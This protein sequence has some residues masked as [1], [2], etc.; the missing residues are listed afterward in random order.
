MT[1]ETRPTVAWFF[2]C[3]LILT[4]NSVA[5]ANDTQSQS[6][7]PKKAKPA[8]SEPFVTSNYFW[9]WYTNGL[10]EFSFSLKNRSGNDVKKVRFRVIF[11]DRQGNQ[12][13]FQDSET[14]AYSVIP[15]GMTERESVALDIATGSS[16]R[17]LS[18]S[19][20]VEILG[21]EQISPESGSKSP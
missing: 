5:L 8:K 18:A 16:V 11:Y 12:I 3:V 21:F 6:S 9:S 4:A 2:F 19:Q 10:T 14:P 1:T 15:N 20:K 13:H 7:A 17:H